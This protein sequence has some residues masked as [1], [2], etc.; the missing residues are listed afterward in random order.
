MN[1]RFLY[2]AALVTLV[3]MVLGC[4]QST[5]D[6]INQIPKDLA[7]GKY[8]NAAEQVES[9]VAADS[10]SADAIFAQGQLKQY[11][12]LDW[13]ALIDYIEA[14]PINDGY[15]PAM[16]AF[17]PLAVKLDYFDNAAKMARL[18]IKRRPESAIPYIILA[19]VAM[20]RNK[21]DSARVFADQAAELSDDDA[22]MKL[23]RAK[24]DIRT[25][26]DEIIAETMQA[27]SDGDFSTA[28]H[29][30]MLTDIYDYLYMA[31]SAIHYA[32][33]AVDSD[34]NIYNRH[35]L[36]AC[37]VDYK[38][39][40]EAEA[41]IA[42]LIADAP[43]FGPVHMTAAEVTWLH[44]YKAEADN[45][46]MLYM[47]ANKGTPVIL[48]MH[49]DL[50]KKVGDKKMPSLE[51]QSAYVLAD[52]MK[53]PD[54]YIRPLYLKMMNGFLDAGNIVDGYDFFQESE[55]LFDESQELYF[56]QAELM[57]Y[58]DDAVDSAMLMV[59]NQ[60]HRH[61]DDP[62][63]LAGA[64]R[65]FFR[66]GK[67]E[68]ARDIYHDLLTMPYPREDYFVNLLRIYGAVNDVAAA[69]KLAADLP[70]RY[71]NSP[72]VQM[73]LRDFYRENER[74]DKA[75]G[76][77]ARLY[78]TAPEYLPYIHAY[79]DL[80]GAAKGPDEA[81]ALYVDFRNSHPELA[82]AHYF[83]ARFDY[84]NGTGDDIAEL[85]GEAV[86]IDSGYAM[87]Y[88]LLGE[89]F[90]ANGQMDSAL[91]YYEKTVAL[92][93]PTPIAYHNLARYYLNKNDSLARAAGL[94]MAA[95]RYF[96]N[97]RRGYLLL[98]KI[99]F[100]DG[101]FK[102]ARDQFFR[103]AKLFPDDAEYHFWLGKAHVRMDDKAKA[104]T[105]L[106]KSLDLNVPS[107]EKEEAREILD[108]L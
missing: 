100:A 33:K 10:T 93:W 58:F 3:F 34:D 7:S 87:A 107:P 63:W 44:G 105:A 84:D 92:Q 53:Y 91:H 89:Y 59:D 19:E 104:R 81:R 79:A 50:Y 67:F 20:R 5:E 85:L 9:I 32:R 62:E 71:R 76:Y 2:S 29:F 65:Y 70:I 66:R 69:D 83:L 23:L 95:V 94:A 90:E 72:R 24:I 102:M 82:D 86:V 51:W 28:D 48:E 103:G 88:E 15:L 11:R 39:L 108:N 12:G 36:A 8:Q 47:Q 30:R 78:D 35:R 1:T 68:P 56:I 64:A 54:D 99:Y 25:Y 41:I 38:R 77:A 60:V 31:D 46:F 96:E 18:Y 22:G 14:S 52:N 80:L 40:Y 43:E 26:D 73:A 45:E 98:G 16:E 75:L 17:M 37:L 106:R 42:D 4:S 57:S 27:L 55:G 13:D 21:L 97:D 101:K 74:F 61:R 6:K 49:G